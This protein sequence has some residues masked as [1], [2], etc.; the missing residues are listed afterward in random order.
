MFN[1]VRKKNKNSK[2]AGLFKLV[3]NGENKFVSKYYPLIKENKD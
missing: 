3:Y 1:K 2:K